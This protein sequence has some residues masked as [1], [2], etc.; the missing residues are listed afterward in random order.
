MSIIWLMLKGG[1]I[2]RGILLCTS[3]DLN[4]VCLFAYFPLS[5]FVLVLAPGPSFQEGRKVKGIPNHLCNLFLLIIIFP[6]PLINI[7]ITPP[8]LFFFSLSFL[9]S[10]LSVQQVRLRA[11]SSPRS[12]SFNFHPFASALKL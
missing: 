2:H 4:L 1:G 7:P 11:S 5:W 6:L 10:A 9:K 12:C 8:T 3:R